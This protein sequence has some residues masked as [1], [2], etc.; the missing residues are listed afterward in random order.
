MS[1]LLESAVK[2]DIDELMRWFPDAHAVDIWGGPK[3]RYPFDRKTFYEDCRWREFSNYRLSAPD[4][5]LV[6]Y[7]QLG[8]RYD[9][10]HLAR[11]IVKPA[12]RGQGLGRKLIEMMI[13]VARNE[14]NFS[15]IALFVY[16]DNEPARECYRSLGFE[17]QA[18]PEKAPMKDRCFY[19]ARD[20]N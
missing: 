18:Y 5:S 12:M 4:G 14:Q 20:I 1:S 19:L 8:D 9:R 17:I 7:G 11:L 2:G 6:A 3:F 10:A 13:D 15:K 16:R